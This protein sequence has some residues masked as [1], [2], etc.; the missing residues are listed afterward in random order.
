MRPDTALVQLGA[1]ARSPL[2]A[3]ASA[4]VARRTAAVVARVR[5]MGVEERDIRTVTYTVEPLTSPGGDR[6]SPSIVGYHAVNVVEVRI[7]Q[8]DRVGLVLDAA[9]LAGASVV[10]ALH[11]T[12]A[13]P[14]AAEAEA[15]A[16]AVRDAAARARQLAEAAGVALG[17]LLSLTEGGAE[18]EPRISA[19]MSERALAAAPGPVE[20]GQLDVVIAV[21]ARYRI[22]AP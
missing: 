5:E 8:L 18:A 22:V 21:E 10:R 14:A 4:E 16:R 13:D 11:F 6:E 15:R 7:R 2:L 12:V 1:E 20:A 3:D 19:Y 17:P 9:V